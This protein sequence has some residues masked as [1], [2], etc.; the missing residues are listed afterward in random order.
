MMNVIK[1]L[2]SV[3]YRAERKHQ[4]QLK[5]ILFEFAWLDLHIAEPEFWRREYFSQEFVLQTYRLT[6]T[7]DKPT[8]TWTLYAQSKHIVAP[9]RAAKTFSTEQLLQ[10][11][12]EFA[13]ER[14]TNKLF[15]HL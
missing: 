3:T 4:R 7:Y 2:F 12:V 6:V 13:I 15:S 5:Q 14:V 8:D 1:Y 11:G 9:A 10:Y